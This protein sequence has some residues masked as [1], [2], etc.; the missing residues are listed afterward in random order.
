MKTL[1]V[2]IVSS[3]CTLGLLGS[4][5]LPWTITGT[6]ELERLRSDL[7]KA[8]ADIARLSKP[9]TPRPLWIYTP[10]RSPLNYGSY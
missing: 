2:M 10:R 9:A 8:N 7:D 4:G 1:I 5:A 6:A 3:A